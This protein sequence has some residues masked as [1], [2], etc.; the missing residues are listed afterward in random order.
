MFDGLATGG[1][2]LLDDLADVE[3]IGLDDE[4]EEIGIVVALL[5]E[6]MVEGAFA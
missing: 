5:F 2:S 3:G 1:G 4:L 6:T